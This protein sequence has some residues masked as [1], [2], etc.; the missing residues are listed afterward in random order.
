MVSSLVKLV[1]CATILFVHDDFNQVCV[2][3]VALSFWF[4]ICRRI[5]KTILSLPPFNAILCRFS[6]VSN[7]FFIVY[8][9]LMLSLSSDVYMYCYFVC[10]CL[11]FFVLSK[12]IDFKLIQLFDFFFNSIWVRTSSKWKTKEI[13]IQFCAKKNCCSHKKSICHEQWI[14]N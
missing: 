10:F 4:A 7:L 11:L 9:L 1:T 5:P 13:K 8:L 6:P 12:T 14:N 3:N 2:M